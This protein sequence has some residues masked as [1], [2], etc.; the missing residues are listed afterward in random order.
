MRPSAIMNAPYCPSLCHRLPLPAPPFRF[1]DLP[2]EIRYQIIE[3]VVTEPDF[4]TVRYKTYNRHPQ[5]QIKNRAG[6]V[7]NTAAKL[8]EEKRRYGH[9]RMA[10]LLTCRQLY[11]DGWRTYYGKNTFIFSYDVFKPF[12][13]ELPLR[14]QHQ[15]RRIV[16]RMH[17]YRHEQIWRMLAICKGLEYLEVVLHPPGNL[18]YSEWDIHLWGAKCIEGLKE[19][20]LK[21]LGKQKDLNE[22]ELSVFEKDRALEEEVKTL[23]RERIKNR[24]RRL[25]RH[26][27]DPNLADVELNYCAPPA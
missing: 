16:F 21:R 24:E 7:I 10:L 18:Q 23:I 1:L 19:L 17:K 2:P 4:I 3:D 14:C 25:S 11:H 26:L 20:K 27:I 6:H 22:Q 9:S 13:M 8:S 15:L 12:L 5:R